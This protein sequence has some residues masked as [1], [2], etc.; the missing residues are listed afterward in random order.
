MLKFTKLSKK[1]YGK[2]R[3]YILNTNY[4][5]CDISLGVFI[6][7]NDQCFYEFAEFDETL[8]VKIK[9]KG[10]TWFLPPVGKNFD[11]AVKEIE[12]YCVEKELKVRFT[13]VD[14]DYLDYFKARYGELS[15][16]TYN[17]DFSD[18]LYDIDDIRVFSGKKYGGQRNHIN[19][20]KKLYPDYKFA[21]L[22]KSDL[23]EVELF[24]REYAHEHE[25][26]GKIE[27]EEFK[28]TLKI[29]K[30]FNPR[31]FTGGTMRANGKIVSFTVGEIA[32]NEL[33]IHVEKALTA[34]AGI[35]PATFN[36]F[37]KACCNSNVKFVNREDDV[38]DP[39]LRISK[40]QYHPI[41][42]VNKNQIIVDYPMTIKKMPVVRGER[43][44]LNSIKKSDAKIYFKLYTQ[45]ENNRYWGYD[46]T[47]DVKVLKENV[48]Y[49]MQSKDFKRGVNACFAIR[50]SA[51]G[52]MLGE[53][54]LYNFDYERGVE[55]G[56]RLFKKHQG[57]GIAR[58]ALTALIGYAEGELG[59]KV[60]AKCY[61]QNEKSLRLLTNCDFCKVSKI[62][63]IWYFLRK[64]P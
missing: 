42:L 22:K 9:L 52:E 14:D 8:I 1:I 4:K 50:T 47:K 54:V 31:Y 44:V 25:I 36:A 55:V 2:I 5:A 40:T 57:K 45:K 26:M 23:S 38:G 15:S 10:E 3:E 35:Y 33:I 16:F 12:K 64:T 34:Y 20:F 11:Q 61:E 63:K 28:N 6:M 32:G 59:L 39:G 17:R 18:Y 56:I 37:C 19:K 49:E 7:W 41:R 51:R 62:G 53:A 21:S 13:S 43:V 29:L 27:K 30:N 58:D 46:Y 48:F 24:L 60:R